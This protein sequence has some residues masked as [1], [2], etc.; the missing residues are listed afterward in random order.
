MVRVERHAQDAQPLDRVP[1][2]GPDL[3]ARI[4]ATRGVVRKAGEDRD[5][6]P[7]LCPMKCKLTGSSCRCAHFWRKIL[8]DIENLHEILV[9]TK[10]ECTLVAQGAS[11]FGA[12]SGVVFPKVCISGKLL[13]PGEA[14]HDPQLHYMKPVI[15][16]ARQHLQARV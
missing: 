8:R 4:Q 6:V 13:L 9:V 12:A 14:M 16:G 5:L 1:L 11:T 3:V 2:P 7:G 10:L 15:E